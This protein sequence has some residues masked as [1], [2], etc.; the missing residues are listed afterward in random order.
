TFK[1]VAVTPEGTES[2]NAALINF[3]IHPYFWQTVWFRLL[4]AAIAFGCITIYLRLYFKRKYKR[5][6]KILEAEAALERE[7][8][9]ISKDMHDELGASLT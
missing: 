3:T 9:R 8:M 6:V 5:K 7:R 1:I 2:K 4:S